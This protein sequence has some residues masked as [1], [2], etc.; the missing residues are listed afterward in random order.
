MPEKILDLSLLQSALAYSFILLLLFIVRK[1]QLGREGEILNASIRMTVQLILA[2]YAL[3]FIF[4]NP[5]WIITIV[6]LLIMQI[7]AIHNSIQRIKLPV[8]RNFRMILGLSLFV[9]TGITLIFFLFFVIRVDPWYAP[10]Y[11]IPIAGMIVGNAMTGVSLAA[12][13]LLQNMETRRNEVETSLM[14]GAKPTDAIK[15]LGDQ[16]FE[17]AIM[18]SIQAMMGMGLVS[19][20]GMMTGQILSGTFPLTAIKYQ[21]AIV[22][23]NTGGVT[24]SVILMLKYASKTFFNKEEQLS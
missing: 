6:Y 23:A 5:H 16:A 2:G 18:P 4:A 3:T 1:R 15:P 12:N 10:R 22:L 13:N 7:F 24:L 11:C 9:G 19:L 20:P 14:L 21:I 17:T 8:T